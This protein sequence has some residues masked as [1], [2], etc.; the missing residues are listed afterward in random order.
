MAGAGRAGADGAGN[1]IVWFAASVAPICDL[2]FWETPELAGGSWGLAGLVMGTSDT[3]AMRRGN[4]PPWDDPPP[5][6]PWLSALA[7]PFM[8]MTSPI[9]PPLPGMV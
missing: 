9:F 7:R 2:A 4:K 5:E 8:A 6:A 3:A 1:D